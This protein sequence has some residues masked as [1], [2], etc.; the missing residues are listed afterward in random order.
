ML[1]SLI[2]VAA[3]AWGQTTQP[4]PVPP[5]SAASATQPA[6]R[7][8][9]PRMSVM[10]T[11]LP[12]AIQAPRRP[13]A[14]GVPTTSPA[15]DVSDMGLGNLSG[16]PVDIEVTSDGTIVL[17]GDEND[18]AIL[19]KFIS[20]MDSERP[21]EARV[22]IFLIENGD[23]RELAPKIQQLWDVAKKPVAGPLRAE[24]RMTIIPE[25][26][27][28]SLMVAATAEN[29]PEVEAIIRQLDEPTPGRTMQLEMIQLKHIKATEAEATL[30]DLLKSFQERRG[31]AHQIV[32]V[33]ADPRSNALFIN[34]PEADLKQIKGW[35]DLMD[36][37]PSP[38]SGGVVK[39]AVFPLTKAKSSELIRALE[40]MLR[41]NTDAAKGAVEQ[42]RRLQTVVTNPD[43]SKRQLKDLNLDKPIKLLSD[44]GGNAVIAATVEENF[45]PL[46]ELIRL[47]D[48]VPLGGEVAVNVFPLDHAD[49]ESVAASLKTLFDQG[50]RLGD[51]PAKPDVKRAATG[52]PGDA[53]S[54]NI[55]ISTDKRTNTLVVSGKAEQLLLVK[56]IVKAM[57]VEKSY[58]KYTP[59]LVKLEHASVKSI[60]E[61]VT[62][63][64]EQRQAV[65]KQSATP[66]VAERDKAVVIPDVRTNCLIVVATDEDYKEI[67]KLAQDLDGVEDD[68]LGQ[69][70]ILNLVADLPAAEVATRIEDLWK[71]RA[72]IRKEG[73]LPEDKPV[74]IPDTRSNSLIVAS[75]KDDYD[76][77]ES[78]VKK[79][80]AQP[81]A[82]MAEIRLLEMKHN[83]VS[84]VSEI[85]NKLFEERLKI[86]KIEGQKDMPTDRIVIVPD[87][88]TRT[89]LI[90]SSKANYDEVVK[91]VAK[92][93]VPPTAEGVYKTF[94][95]QYAD[96]ENAAKFLDD[97]FKQGLYTGADSKN[98]PEGLMKVTVV[99]DPRTRAIIVSASPQNLAICESLLGQI[100]RKEVPTLFAPRIVKL[101][102]A[103]AKTIGD[104]VQ[105][106]IDQ[107]NKII[108]QSGS[109]SA[110][111]REKVMAF[112]DVRTNSLIIVARDDI[113]ESLASLVKR[114]DGAEEDW[115]GQI[116][117]INLENLTASDMAKNIEELWKRRAEKRKEGG[118][119]E[120]LPVVVPDT[121]SNALVVASS[122]S[123]FESIMGLVNKLEAQRLRPMS[124]IRLITIQ[125]NDAT[126]LA[127]TIKQLWDE[128]LKNSLAEGQKDK[129]GDKIAIADDPI[130][131]TI[132]VAASKPNFEEIQQI[133]AKLDVPPVTEGLFRIFPIR[134]ADISK[135]EKL[136]GDLFDKGLYTGSADKKNLPESATKVTI[137][138]D[139]R[140]SSLIVS[141]S[142]QNLAIVEQLLKEVDR[143]DVPSLPAG[144]AFFPI[145]HADVV[146]VADLMTQMFEGMQSSM[147]SE[148]K[149]QLNVKILPDPR[150]RVVIVAGTK[151]AIRRAEELVAKLDQ[152]SLGAAYSVEVYKLKEAQASRLEPVMTEMFEKRLG[153]DAQ[154]KRIPIHVIADDGS[155]SL[156]ITASPDDHK[157]AKHLVGLLD[158]KSDMAEQL[159]VIPLAKAQAEQVAEMLEKVLEKQQVGQE[160]GV[161][162]GLT[163]EPRTNSLLIWASPDM[164]AQISTIVRQLDDAKP[165]TEMALRVFPL[166]NAK[167]EDLA[168]LLDEFFEKAGSSPKSDKEAKTMIISFPVKDPVTGQETSQT[169]VHQ[170]VTISPDKNTN[171]LM[172]LAP[173]K[174]IAMVEMMVQMLDSVEPQ[175]ADIKVFQLRNADAS[176]MKDLL[177][178]L[179][180]VGKGGSQGEERR[181]FV[182]AGAEGAVPVAGAGSS[183]ELAFG[184]DERT[185][186]LIVT[187]GASYIKIVEQL[188][189]RLDY[190]DM[191]ERVS[192]VIQLR[193]RPAEEVAKTMKAYYEEESQAYEKAAGEGEAKLKQLQRTVNVQEGGEGSNTL[194][195]SYDPRMES[196][197]INMI[198]ELD[199]APA[200][201]MIQVLIAEVTLNEGF[202]MGLEFALQELNFTESAYTGPNDVLKGSGHDV[203]GGT[204]LGAQGTSGLGGISLTVTS[205]DFN[206]LVR[207]LQ[208]E[209]RLEILSRPSIMVQDN[210]DAEITIGERVP[211][212]QDV[213]VSGNGVVTP[214]VTYEK[215]GVILKVTPIVN[216]DGFVSMKIEP[217]ISAIGTSSVT[218][219]TGVSLPT[220]TERSA[221]T[222][223]TVK[224][225]ETI[226]IGGLITSR[227]N[228]G[229]NKVPL[230]GDVP[231]LG[232]L[233][234]ATTRQNTKTELLMILT[235]HVVR[236]PEEAR[237]LSMQM[238]DQTGLNEN[239]RQSPLMEQLRVQPEEDLFG[240]D[241]MLKPTGEKKPRTD[242]LEML[243]P[244]VEPLG[245]PVSFTNR[246]A[247]E[248][249]MVTVQTK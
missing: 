179:M 90:A 19:E 11:T 137:V 175:A 95:V 181:A 221:S 43:G 204:D 133:V 78:L 192:S 165:K 35:I 102:H 45:E 186:S 177:E 167:A 54:Y 163:P 99:S 189:L 180:G 169:L 211:T 84:K 106:L 32:T 239:I 182:L 18:V 246:S 191:E 174:S 124:E 33:K 229:E 156:V 218:V 148:Q 144:A 36:V 171:S 235:P 97:F 37:L 244:E 140:S 136:I 173:E 2:L 101:E 87:P 49:V 22:E 195:V 207:A 83:D 48:T 194:V 190:L 51:V 8:A 212:V 122:Q 243:G 74:V 110:A 13:V 98:I 129:P 68:W 56:Q 146:N 72:E 216:P 127:D 153:S 27:S 115:L 31:A 30:K 160:K 222:A 125:N 119:P 76:A 116:H 206:L 50:Q 135:A 111:E 23:A 183:I 41:A 29:M 12:S 59:K 80:M 226:I 79:L 198:N 26:R 81:V 176:E 126:K 60:A 164:F 82:P 247:A 157:M 47:L 4:T 73:G 231:I 187:G 154:G 196:Q 141:G 46:G 203:I 219:S 65:L 123:D 215:V 70:R 143:E 224:D 120:D 9:G 24:D 63:I 197:V 159:H 7:A 93:D 138:S 109:K 104:V 142:P 131:R 64:A 145:Q 228:A 85:V 55:G 52:L 69:M 249:Q 117:I 158:R 241:T 75:S 108:E 223:V 114:L 71:R 86:S 209:G 199:R 184:V 44:D 17:Y 170:D 202:E 16:N 237:A 20:Q 21:V 201:V 234:R 118:L 238:R 188:V 151:L 100:D 236:T 96:P 105:K 185:N 150:S 230:A 147:S 166:K 132:I 58:G 92:L 77:I 94:F 168:E 232:N 3:V 227:E 103:D 130:T 5:R 6:V 240:P 214:S 34:A 128:R 149:D 61:V 112:P 248:P 40:G 88:L 178:D 15:A 220:F 217:E 57:D 67:A 200:M 213:V 233:F 208:T 1:Q 162:F 242:D 39:M 121:R 91:L 25:P 205:E 113:Y 152:E 193:N 107:Q 62:K 210:Q 66:A 139:L 10:P 134:N 53:L 245:P 155:N 42:I 38:E 172:V 89:M 161:G 14:A 225:N 28:N